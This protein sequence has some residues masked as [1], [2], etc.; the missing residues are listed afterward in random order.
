MRCLF[1]TAAA[2]SLTTSLSFAQENSLS[3]NDEFFELF[4][5]E[6]TPIKENTLTVIDQNITSSQV[7]SLDQTSSQTASNTSLQDQD[8][9]NYPIKWYYAF[10]DKEIRLYTAID[11]LY[12]TVSEPGMFYATTAS[13]QYPGQ[14]PA[15][16]PAGTYYESGQLGKIEKQSFGWSSG[17]R[18]TIGYQ[19]K[20]NLWNLTAD[21]TYFDIGEKNTIYR[22]DSLFGYL[23]GMN[24]WQVTEEM[25]DYA[26]SS[27]TLNYQNAKLMLGTP[28]RNFKVAKVQLLFG[29]HA[30]WLKQDWHVNFHPLEFGAINYNFRENKTWGVGFNAMGK[31]DADLGKG[32]SFGINGFAAALIGQ[33][34][35][36]ASA[37]TDP[38]WNSG[39]GWE[40]FYQSPTYQ[41]MSQFMIS[42]QIAW[43]RVLKKAAIR[44]EAAYEF[45]AL[46]NMLD[47]Y[48]DRLLPFE[49]APANAP[50]FAK[51]PSIQNNNLY[52]HG[53]TIRFGAGF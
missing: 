1:L 32:F 45:N 47:I 34:S 43:S 18:G 40:N 48:R 17:V 19:F 3:F 44:I 27:I 39:Y 2:L 49:P 36:N 8:F 10:P 52:L 24:M 5:E 46:V 53:L 37:Y 4:H 35:L 11:Y 30:T 20:H 21:Y 41:F 31:F 28:W 13:Q 33:Q 22:P 26:A 6:K 15:V 42:P 7:P 16:L 25:A 50:Q 29:A 51:L 14:S 23:S 38:Q 9:H 12:W